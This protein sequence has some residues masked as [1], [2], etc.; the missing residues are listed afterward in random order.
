MENEI[1][2]S[3]YYVLGFLVFTNIG[4][5]GSVLYI[6]FKAVWWAS[7][8]DSRV[9]EARAMGVR[10]HKRIDEIKGDE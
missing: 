8:L 7:K 5:I 6:G 10:A 1:P 4:T 3:I 2:K 9:N